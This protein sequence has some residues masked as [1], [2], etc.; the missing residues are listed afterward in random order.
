[1]NEREKAAARDAALRGIPFF[2]GGHIILAVPFDDFC[3]LECCNQCEMGSECKG[4]IH[5]MCDF[6][7]GKFY[8]EFFFKFVVPK[9]I[10]K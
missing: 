6:V 10:N 1:M 8:D 4:D 5:E 7:N 2:C 9:S 3:G